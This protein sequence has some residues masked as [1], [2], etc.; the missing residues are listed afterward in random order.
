MKTSSRLRY[1]LYLSILI[2]GCTTGKNALQKGNYD[3]SVQ[4]SVDRLRN[5]PKNEE[6]QQVLATAYE[7]A[8]KDHLNK[9]Q[10]A[11]ISADV[12]RWEYILTNYEQLNS[13]AGEINSCAACQA[14]VPAPQQFTANIAEAKL[15]AAAVR[16]ERGLRYLD[17]ADR[18]SAKKAYYDFERAKQFAPN[19]KDVDKKMDDAYW[20]AVVR[21]VVEPVQLNSSAYQLSNA[22]FQQQLDYFISNYRNNKFVLFYSQDQAVSQKIRPDQVLSLSFDDFMVGQTFVKERVEKM[23][24][25]SVIIGQIRNNKPIYATVKA[26]FSVFDKKVASSGQLSMTISDWQTQKVIRQQRLSGTYVWQDSW[27]TYKG[28]E[29][30]LSK[31]QLKQLGKREVLPP[32]PEVLFAEFTKPIYA[33]VVD[34]V[35]YFYNQY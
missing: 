14:I 17:E 6:A 12:L 2:V 5:S 20:A 26:S 13:L 7:L 18:A 24:R 28:D 4:K 21:V 25:D 15:N 30:A 11:K 1:F 22:Y 33:Q 10:Q 19:Y 3:A 27:A 31:Q 34:E 35:N 23:K 16:Y 29:R 9:I 8:L 32:G